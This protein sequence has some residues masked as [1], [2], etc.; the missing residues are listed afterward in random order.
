MI[1]RSRWL[2]PSQYRYT[3]SS[4]LKKARLPAFGK[5]QV[6]GPNGQKSEEARPDGRTLSLLV[7]GARNRLYL[8]FV[9]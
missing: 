3:D 2:G 6:L 8:L 7:A 1:R 5:V 9:A 4:T